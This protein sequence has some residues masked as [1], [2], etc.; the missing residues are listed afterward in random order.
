MKRILTFLLIILI[1][2][3][4]LFG[5]VGISPN[6][7]SPDPSAGLDVNF[8]NKGFL[9]PRMTFEQRNAIQDPAEG[10]MVYCTNCNADGSGLISVYQA[11]SWKNLSLE[12]TVPRQVTNR[13]HNATTTEIA[14]SWDPVPI[15]TGYKWN[16]VPDYNTAIDLGT[17]TAYTETGLSC[18]TFYMR[19]VW[20]YNDCGHYYGI[21]LYDTTL[22]I[23]FSPA[24]TEGIHVTSFN[25]IQW[26]WNTVNDATGYKWNTSNDLSSAIDLG[27]ATTTTET[28]LLCGTSYTRYVWAYNSCGATTATILTQATR[29][30]QA[31]PG[32]ITDE[33]DGKIYNTVLIGCRCWMAENLNTGAMISAGQEQNNHGSIEKYC[34]ENTESNCAVY[35]GLYQWDNMMQWSTEPGAQG[36]CPSG[37]HIPTM[38]DWSALEDFLGGSSVAGGKMKETGFEHWISP[39]TGATNES[40]FTALPGGGWYFDGAVFLGLTIRT[41]YWSSSE[42]SSANAGLKTISYYSESFQNSGNN[43]KS[44]GYSLRCIMD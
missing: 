2:G 29:T 36:I 9:P 42:Y 12:C 30:I 23:P 5:Q 43:E 41:A 21:E 40:G 24:P 37:W 32:S 38:G 4:S 8:A 20:S 7:A 26:N 31:C 33:R 34:Y 15:A 25:E 17:D 3:C 27:S 39:N 28:G 16:S 44:Y 18:A 10:L 22:S 11:G 35:G 13:N 19:W 14:W 1:A 6:A